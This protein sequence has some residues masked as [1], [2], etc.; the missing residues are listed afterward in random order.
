MIESYDQHDVRAVLCDRHEQLSAD[1]GIVDSMAAGS[2]GVNAGDARGLCRTG[3]GPNSC[4]CATRLSFLRRVLS[5]GGV[6]LS[7]NVLI[8]VRPRL[9]HR[10]H[11]ITPSTKP[12]GMHGRSHQW[13]PPNSDPTHMQAPWR[14][15]CHLAWCAL[16]TAQKVLLPHDM[17]SRGGLL[18][19]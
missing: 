9:S 10:G 1:P 17:W 5:I 19:S 15:S 12:T 3:R 18:L 13:D 7:F 4:V 2:C 16:Q 6:E 11:N 8:T 14:I